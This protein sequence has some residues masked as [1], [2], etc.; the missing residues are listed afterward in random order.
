MAA[1]GVHLARPALTQWMH[2]TADLLTPVY[3]AQL[4]S[5]LESSVLAI[6]KTPIKAGCRDRGVL[7][8]GFFWPLYGDRA[9]LVCP[10]SETRGRA[11]LDEFLAGYTCRA[12]PTTLSGKF[13]P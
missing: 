5:V 9:E 2:R 12:T 6:D 13:G 8:T 1:A 3:E 7:K 11:F 10:F 4:S